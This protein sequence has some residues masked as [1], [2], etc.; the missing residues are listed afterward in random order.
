MDK[1]LQYKLNNSDSQRSV[2]VDSSLKIGLEQDNNTL[3][4]GELNRILNVSD[5]FNQERENCTVY[6]LNGTISTIFS[7]VLFN[8]TG[9]NSYGYILTN[10]LFRDRS[11]PSNNIN[12]NDNEDLTYREALKLH[13]KDI[14]GWYG[15]KNPDNLSESLC[16]WTDMEPNRELF[17]FAPSNSIKNWDITI[18]YP[19]LSADTFMT[20]GGL[21]CV[22]ILPVSVG[23]RDMIAIATP[24]KHGLLQGDTVRIT[25]LSSPIYDGDYQVIRIGLDNGDLQNNYFVIDIDPNTGVS[26]GVSSRMTR[27]VGSEP[28]IYYYRKFKKI[29]TINS[30]ELNTDDYDIYPLNFSKTLF[31]DKNYQFIINEDIDITN[32]VDNLGR[33]LS[34]LYLTIIKTDGNQG[35][36]PIFTSIKSGIEIPFIGN[37]SLFQNSVPD[38]RRIHNGT[39]PN[40]H[41]PLDTSVSILDNEFYGDIVSYNRFEVKE[42]VLGEIR[43]QFNTFNRENGGIVI[44]P[45]TGDNEGSFDMGQRF[46]GNFYKPHYQ[47]RLREFSNYIEQGDSSTIGIPNYAVDLGDGRWLWRDQL[48]LG[49]SD[50]STTPLDYPFLNGCH[51]IHQNYLISL[52]R[53]DPFAQYGL[54]YGQFPRDSFGDKITDKFT[55]KKSQDAC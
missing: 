25:G 12:F 45:S 54:Y 14:D 24:I 10:P 33:P 43:H 39:T 30:V 48:S 11:Y 22:E 26:I 34:E 3:P 9:I 47:I 35:D 21:L 15:F 50:V 17:S 31:N 23:N 28:S 41:T 13:I 19:A 5:R 46:E 38:I 4:V 29:Q 36:G 27:M 37:V 55:V 8:T 52:R 49:F 51:Y 40:P 1:R 6:R 2:N 42:I 20:Q 44:D 16:L 7:N 32:L 53:Q 18:T